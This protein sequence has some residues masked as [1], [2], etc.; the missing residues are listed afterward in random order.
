MGGTPIQQCSK[1]IGLSGTLLFDTT[2][3]YLEG[4]KFFWK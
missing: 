3:E 1:T 4:T 2:K